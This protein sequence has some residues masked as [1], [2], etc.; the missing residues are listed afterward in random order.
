MTGIVA[1]R[2]WEPGVR[3]S[4]AATKAAVKALENAGI[5]RSRLGLLIN[6]SVS[7]DYIEP[8]VASLV[9]GNLGLGSECLNFDVGNA[10]LA[11]LNGIEVAGNMIERGQVDYA[12]VVDGEDSRQVTETTIKRLLE[13]GC[14]LKTFRD[15]FAS[16]T[17]GSGAGA[18]VLA[19]S[20]L[21]HDGRRI[22]GSVSLSATEYNHLC[23]GQPDGMITDAGALLKAGVELARRTWEKAVRELDWE[24]GSLDLLILHQVSAVH[25]ARL[26]QVLGLDMAKV[27]KTYPE[28]GNIG[29]AAVPITLSK[30]VESGL[31]K[32]GCRVAL[33]GI[34]SGL[35]CSMMDVR[36]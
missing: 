33:L 26:C 18:M 23:R 17:L 27:Y 8:S 11:F 15:N 32:P 31:V 1:R 25:T 19:R 4:L 14:D 16:L 13:P 30:A 12:L 9:H 7:K 28:Y 20:D 2:F 29:P 5:D 21:G 24:A 34:G 6:T 36:W 22:R 10:C 3:P 35:N